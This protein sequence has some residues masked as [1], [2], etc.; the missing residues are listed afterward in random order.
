MSTIARVQTSKAIEEQFRKNKPSGVENVI[1]I[2]VVQLILQVVVDTVDFGLLPPR[3]VGMKG[4]VEHVEDNRLVEAQ[5]AYVI[6]SYPP[7]PSSYSSKQ[8]DVKVRYEGDFTV[9]A[10][11]YLKLGLPLTITVNGIEFSG[12]AR[13][14]TYLLPAEPFVARVE[15]SFISAPSIKFKVSPIGMRLT[16]A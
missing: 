11:V 2:A 6:P 16:I 5:N 9:V 1:I 12:R 7:S 14:V 15:V 8:M 3:I 13:L 10:K 4:Y